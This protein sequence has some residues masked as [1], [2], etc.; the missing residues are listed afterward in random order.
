MQQSWPVGL[1]YW[2]IF[3]AIVKDAEIWPFAPWLPRTSGLRSLWNR[4]L[5]LW[6]PRILTIESSRTLFLTSRGR[7][8]NLVKLMSSAIIATWERDI[9]YTWR[10]NSFH[11]Q[12][13]INHSS[14]IVFAIIINQMSNKQII[15]EQKVHEVRNFGLGNAKYLLK[16]NVRHLG[17]YFGNLSYL[18]ADSFYLQ[19]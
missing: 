15:I 8:T 11:S 18:I 7:H 3:Y 5:V 2:A 10:V 4:E 1:I 19:L 16:L 13:K 14:E 9:S 12:L 6:T 17:F